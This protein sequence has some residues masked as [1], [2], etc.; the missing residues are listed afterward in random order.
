[1]TQFLMQLLVIGLLAVPLYILAVAATAKLKT[2][3]TKET[4]VLIALGLA[5]LAVW[6][7]F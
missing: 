1:M 4:L 3:P 6:Q 2:R 7:P 5:A